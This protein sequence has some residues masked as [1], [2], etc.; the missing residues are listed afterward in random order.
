MQRYCS[1][2]NPAA[3]WMRGTSG[4]IQRKVALEVTFRWWLFSCLKIIGTNWFFLL[5]CWSKNP[6]LWLDKK[7]TWLH[8]TNCGSLRWCPSLMTNVIHKKPRHQFIDSR[9]FDNQR[10]RQS[11]LKSG[12]TCYTQPKFFSLRCYLPLIVIFMD[13]I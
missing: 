7:H 10:V 8:P 1:S 11:D 12:T 4:H 2:K 5:F 9:E 13:K 3:C 6:A